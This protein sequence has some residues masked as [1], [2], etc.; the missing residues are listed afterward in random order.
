ML[1]T[2]VRDS[3]RCMVDD[4]V[5][6]DVI[7]QRIKDFLPQTW[8]TSDAEAAALNRQLGGQAN[9]PPRSASL[10][11]LNERLRFL[12]YSQGQQFKPH[13]DGRYIRT[14]SKSAATAAAG[15]QGNP[16]PETSFVTVQLY[17]NDG[18]EEEE[19]GS[20]ATC[21]GGKSSLHRF[22]GGST[23]FLSPRDDSGANY[24]IV[25]CHPRAGRVLVFEH[26]LL[27]QGSPVTKGTKY[28]LRTDAMFQPGGKA[29]PKAAA[30]PAVA[31]AAAATAAISE[32][33][34]D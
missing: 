33:M 15:G 29:E 12:K 14:P 25:H 19:E 9:A 11:S 26:H 10:V 21:A 20:A 28:C 23:A 24:G 31:A 30:A 3:T 22:G 6:A 4:T 8:V 2:D 1:R 5:V 34:R 32:P 16:W 7:F 17:L 13:Y 27:H 18:E